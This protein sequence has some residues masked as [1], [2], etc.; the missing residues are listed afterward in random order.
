M[1]RT[2][3]FKGLGV[4]SVDLGL[5]LADLARPLGQKGVTHRWA[6]SP[7]GGVMGVV[8]LD[9]GVGERGFVVV[10]GCRV[11]RGRTDL[12]GSVGSLTSALALPPGVWRTREGEW[13]LVR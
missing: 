13:R 2:D 11:T 4:E 9:N 12:A 10:R 8:V 7:G 1:M 6:T 5:L 3:A